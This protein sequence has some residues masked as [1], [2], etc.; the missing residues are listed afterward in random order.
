MARHVANH[1]F[2]Y[3]P[4]CH[5]RLTP[6]LALN[7]GDSEFWLT[8]TNPDCKTYVNTYIPQAYQ[9]DFHEDLHRIKGNFGGFGSGKTTTSRMELEKTILITPSGTTLI[10]ANVASQY[11]QTI[12]REFEADFPKEFMRYY[13]QQ[14]QF[15]DFK[16]GH[17]VMYR[18]YD[19]PDK[20]RSYNL[21]GWIILEASEVKDEAF[22]QLKTRLRNTAAT[23][24]ERDADGNVIYVNIDGVEVPKIKWDWRE[25]IIESNPAAGWIKN[26]VLNVSDTIKVYGE[27]HDDYYQ[28]KEEI[29]P[30]IASYITTTSANAYLPTDFIPMQIKNKPRWWIDRYIYGSFRYSD[31]LVYPSATK[32]FVE[33]FPIP[34][35]W[36][37]IVAFDYGLADS[38]CFLF[39]A[40]DEQ[41]NLLYFYKEVY[42]NDRSVEELAKLYFDAAT[43]IPVGGFVCA[44]IID[45]K[46]GPRRDYNKKTLA[47]SFLD[48]GISFMP[49]AVDRDARIY[50]LNTYLETGHVRIMD[51]C[52][53]LQMQLRDLKFKAEPTSTTKPWRDEPEDKND[54]AVVC[55]EWIV[56]ELPKDPG[57]LMYGSYYNTGERIDESVVDPVAEYKRREEDWALAALGLQSD[58]SADSSY[59]YNSYNSVDY[60]FG[61]G[62]NDFD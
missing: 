52:P 19:D 14:K 29:D 6:A 59:F 18:P 40:I 3:C 34:R 54:H 43:D 41:K 38:A 45:P 10:G 56:M 61:G 9:A 46:S 22:T 27:A 15:M 49:G 37:R 55:A 8:C 16:N 57:K 20:L 60:T 17:R 62:L 39:G 44:P 42:T 11:E 36:K 2:E 32:W 5:S 28:N 4:R 25:G 50:R 21:T 31:G 24:P 12:K 30:V 23:V 53:Q 48:Y 51:S 13:S 33:Y 58:T 35:N 47:D 7:N 26:D 1:S